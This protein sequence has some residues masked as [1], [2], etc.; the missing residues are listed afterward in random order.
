MK[1]LC[2]II[3]D[4]FLMI[5]NIFTE[6]YKAKKMLTYVCLQPAQ[7]SKLSLKNTPFENSSGMV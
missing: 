3:F 6:I 5:F 4:R 2:I 7:M 1:I